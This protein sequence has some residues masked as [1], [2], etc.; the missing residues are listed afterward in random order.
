MRAQPCAYLTGTPES[1]MTAYDDYRL[2]QQR[3]DAD[4]LAFIDYVYGQPLVRA[5]LAGHLHRAWTGPLPSG[6]TQYVAD[7]GYHGF[8]REIEFR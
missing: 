2:R 8:A 6:V 4:T 5:V 7:S 3:P 1:L